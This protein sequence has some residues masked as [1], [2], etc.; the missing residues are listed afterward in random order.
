LEYGTPGYFGRIWLWKFTGKLPRGP[1]EIP[2]VV[3]TADLSIE[4]AK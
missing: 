2:V 1:S 3:P 4:P